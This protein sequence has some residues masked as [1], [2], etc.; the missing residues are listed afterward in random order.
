M[1]LLTENALADKITVTNNAKVSI[2]HNMKSGFLPF[3]K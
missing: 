3:L 2:S 1:F